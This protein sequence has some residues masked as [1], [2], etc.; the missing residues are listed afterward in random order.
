MVESYSLLINGEMGYVNTF[1]T[2]YKDILVIPVLLSPIHEYLVS[3]PFGILCSGCNNKAPQ[4]VCLKQ[5]KFIVSFL[6]AGTS[7]PWSWFL[8]RTVRDHLF[9]APAFGDLRA[10][11]ANLCILPHPVLCLHLYLAFSLCL[12]VSVTKF[13]LFIRIPVLPD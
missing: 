8:L 3:K 7:R 5:Q 11:C 1:R 9:H 13:P 4:S 2:G 10:I 12:C 6:E